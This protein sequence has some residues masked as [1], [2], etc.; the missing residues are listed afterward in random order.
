VSSL[1]SNAVFDGTGIRL[2]SVSHGY[3]IHEFLSP[4]ANRRPDKYGGSLENRMR[5]PL[6]IFE[7]VRAAFPPAKPVGVATDW[8][9]GGWNLEQT[10]EYAKE[11]KKRRADWVTASSGGASRNLSA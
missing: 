5:F 9:Y 11:L 7:A 2:R 8:V 1:I 3:L 4:I 6:E 10:I